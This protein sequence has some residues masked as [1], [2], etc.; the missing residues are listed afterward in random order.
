M[1][2]RAAFSMGKGNNASWFC[3]TLLPPPFSSFSG[4][5][6]VVLYLG[7]VS[8]LFA[9]LFRQT[10]FPTFLSPCLFSD[11]HVARV[12]IGQSGVRNSQEHRCSLLLTDPRKKNSYMIGEPGFE[13]TCR[14]KICFKASF[15]SIASTEQTLFKPCPLQHLCGGCDT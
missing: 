7:E 15:E 3:T 2:R 4:R 9:L 13:V 8:P 11:C 5:L 10:N 1:H 14:V 12:F 6:A